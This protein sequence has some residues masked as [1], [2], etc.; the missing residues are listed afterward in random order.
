VGDAAAG[1]KFFQA[2]CTACH[3]ATG[4]LA[5]IASRAEDAKTLQNLW[6]S[7]GRALGGG[8]GRR[9]ERSPKQIPTV[10]VTMPGGE[11]VQGQLVRVDD[12]LVTVG[13]DD[14]TT[15]TIRRDGDSPAVAITDPMQRHNE[16]LAVYTN[17][18]MHDVTAYLATLK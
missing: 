1:A 18:N 2:T 17:K 10:K 15:R 9:A 5:G 12:F 8:P 13:F 4:D 11:V 7:G 6:V 14:G 16:L 3:S